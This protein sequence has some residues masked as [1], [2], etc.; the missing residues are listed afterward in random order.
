MA[1]F[2]FEAEEYIGEFPDIK[3]IKYLIYEFEAGA[4]DASESS[5]LIDFEETI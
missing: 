1:I 3:T 4:P 5:H 2:N